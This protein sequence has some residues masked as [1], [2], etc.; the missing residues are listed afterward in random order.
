MSFTDP[1]WD[2]ILTSLNE[3]RNLSRDEAIWAMVQ[4]LDGATDN[5]TIKS[6]LLA[7]KA[8]GE[9]ADEVSALVEAMYQ[10]AQ[11]INIPDQIGR[12]HV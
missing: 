5:Q 6:F 11:L 10:K 3:S 2:Q 4:I 1:S 9:T 12:A 8:K 7:L